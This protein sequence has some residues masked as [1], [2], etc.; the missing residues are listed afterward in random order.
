MHTP[1]QITYIMQE[2]GFDPNN[3]EARKVV[4]RLA[5]AKPNVPIDDRFIALLR[6][7]IQSQA[8]QFASSNTNSTNN[9]LS[10]FMNKI[11]ASALVVLLVVVAGGVWYI[12]R[13]DKPLFNSQQFGGDG[14]EQILSGKY[15]VTAAEE[16]SFGDLAK[17]AIVANGRGG[18]NANSS[19]AQLE[20][21]NPSLSGAQKEAIINGTNPVSDADK[22][23]APGEPYPAPQN[24]VFKYDG[25]DLPQLAQ[26]QGVLKR[27]KPAQPSS[28]VSRI[29]GM[30]SFGLIDLTKFQDVKLQS[31]A[32]VEDREFG[33]GI[34]VDLQNGFVNLYQNWERWPQPYGDVACMGMEI[35]PQ[36]PRISI[37]DLPSDE[38]AIQI[39][40]QFLADYSVSREGYGAP[41]VQDYAWRTF[42]ERST[43]KANYYIPE[44]VQV[45]YPL[46]LE[47]KAVF[48]EG[49]NISGM[50]VTVDARTKRATSLYDLTTK[51]FTI[52]QYKGETDSKRILDVAER[53]GFRN[54]LYT[55]PNVKT[56]TT[57]ELDTPTIEMVK[58][59]Y[60]ADNYKSSDELFVPAYVFPIK[61]WEAA[62]YYRKNVFVPLVADILES[63]R[64]YGQP[65][66]LDSPMPVEPDG[67]NGS[68]GTSSGSAGATE[69]AVLPDPAR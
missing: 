63:D 39:A 60:S 27:T 37:D 10:I 38:E 42:Y 35:C 59:W 26:E 30:L 29:V 14:G 45:V 69:P 32:F 61:N 66:P 33:Y 23:I 64:D 3:A 9:F 15:G 8:A 47:G 52:S 24:Y 4:E 11:L 31:F 55:D 51:Q 5:S 1:E 16:E 21:N 17:V 25:G 28:L 49:G 54:Y 36:P 68:S 7:D 40:D 41:Q 20:L 34:G 13:T 67:G 48:D 18:N 6:E 2:L 44:Q 53:G 22:L 57:L 19:M 12:Q 62:G 65:I 43:D 56:K 58:I 50:N 46:M